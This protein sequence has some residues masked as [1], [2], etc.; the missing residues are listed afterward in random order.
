M[1]ID[2]RKFGNTGWFVPRKVDRAIYS[3]LKCPTLEIARFNKLGDLEISQSLF[4][5]FKENKSQSKPLSNLLSAVFSKSLTLFSLSCCG[6][7]TCFSRL[8]EYR[9]DNQAQHEQSITRYENHDL[10]LKKNRYESIKK[11]NKK[12]KTV[13][14]KSANKWAWQ[15][16]WVTGSAATGVLCRPFYREDCHS[17]LSLCRPENR[18]PWFRTRE[19]TK[20]HHGHTYNPT[21]FY[22]IIKGSISCTQAIPG[23]RTPI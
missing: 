6:R 16:V 5:F 23:G 18:A 4:F 15:T 11:R 12:R 17:Q 22:T 3:L 7:W 21:K 2:P 13:L 20:C 9:A 10:E 14:P 8:A 19:K 1:A